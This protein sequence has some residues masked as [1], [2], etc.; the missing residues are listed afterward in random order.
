MCVQ[1]SVESIGIATDAE[2]QRIFFTNKYVRKVEVVGNDGTGRT[3][4]VEVTN[5]DSG[6][7]INL[8]TLDLKQR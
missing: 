6:H 8:V 4:L 5:V 7:T 1:F 2:R 3:A